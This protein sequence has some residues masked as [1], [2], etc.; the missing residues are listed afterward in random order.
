MF[1]VLGSALTSTFGGQLVCRYFVGLFASATLA[2]NG[3]SVGDQFR[4]VKRAF[5]FPVIAW[6]NIAGTK[7]RK[8][9]VR[10]YMLILGYSTYDGTNCGRLDRIRST[11]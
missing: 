3:A 7:P 11:S 6:A 10:K 8:C 4:P 2:I 5:V 1:F 9:S